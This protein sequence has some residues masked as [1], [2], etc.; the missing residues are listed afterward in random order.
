MRI[1]QSFGD[2]RVLPDFVIAS[3]SVFKRFTQGQVMEAF[4][5][6]SPESRPRKDV[7]D[8]FSG[9]SDRNQIVAANRNVPIQVMYGKYNLP[10]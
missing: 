2:R 10:S 5:K 3:K 7:Y 6:L 9:V 4:S 1:C 8:Y